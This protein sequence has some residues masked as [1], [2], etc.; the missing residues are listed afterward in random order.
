[1]R[2]RFAIYVCSV[3]MFSASIVL[4][5]AKPAEAHWA[6]S[7]GYCWDQC[8]LERGNGSQCDTVPGAYECMASCCAN[9][10]T[11]PYEF[12]CSASEIHCSP[13]E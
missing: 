3:A 9:H 6:P 10:W 1:M 5:I 2:K 4:F 11:E 7:A 13:L 8:G 12:A